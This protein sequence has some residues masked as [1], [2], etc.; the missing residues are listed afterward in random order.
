MKVGFGPIALLPVLLILMA[1][2]SGCDN[3]S[4]PSSEALT[5]AP[6]S[7]PPVQTATPLSDAEYAAVKDF[8]QQLMA[9]DDEWDQIHEDFDKWRARIDHMPCEFGA[10]GSTPFLRSTTTA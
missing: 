10:T 4:S 7:A 3:T 1:F 5:P 2:T 9:V 8:V 6:T